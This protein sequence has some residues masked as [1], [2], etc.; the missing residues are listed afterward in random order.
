V[1][2][3]DFLKRAAALGST[4]TL[5]S[6]ALSAP[7][8]QQ[9]DSRR[10]GKGA[11]VEGFSDKARVR[12]GMAMGG[13]GAGYFELRKNGRFYDW[14]IFN[15]FPKETGPPFTLPDGQ[16]EDRMAGLL[17]FEIRYQV[18]GEQPRIKL[19]QLNDSLYEGAEMG[20]AFTF[21]W[22]QAIESIEYS[23]RF[24]LATLVFQDAEMP[25]DLRLEAWS[26]F[27]PHDVKNSS[28]PVVFF[29]FTVV[30]K[31]S[32]KVEITLLMTARNCAGYD[33]PARFYTTEI[34]QS[35]DGLTVS[36]GSGGMDEKA[37]S[38]GQIA[39]ASLSPASSYYAGWGVRHPYYEQVLRHAS[40]PNIDDTNG[41]RSVGEPPPVWL[42]LTNG[43][44][45]LDQSTQKLIVH[46]PDVFSTVAHT[47][48][49][50]GAGSKAA[51]T[52]LYA[53]NFP[54]LY[55]EREFRVQGSRIEGH[56]YSNF[57]SSAKEAIHHGAQQRTELKRRTLEFLDNFF[58]SDADVD[59]LE[60]VNS[61]LNT[62][63]T[64]GRL[65]NS[66]DFGV[67]EGLSATWSWGPI[68]TIDVMFYGSA[69]IIAL[70]PELQKATMRAHARAQSPKGEI[71]H[72]LL[73]DF[74]RGEDST[75][76]IYHRVDLPG[77]FAIMALRDFF[78]T[79]D[80]AYL[81]EMMPAV[82][83]A[84]DYVLRE[85]SGSD[86]AMPIT[87][88][89][90]TSYD[91]FPMFGYASYLLSQW[92]CAMASVRDACLHLGNKN[93]ADR[94]DRLLTKTR[95]SMEERLWN[96]SYY[97]LFSDPG[98]SGSHGNAGDGCLTD[99][100]AGL[101]AAHSSGLGNLLPPEH[102]QGA[103]RTILKRNYDPSLGLKNCS[104]RADGGLS[105]VD[106]DIWVDQ[107]QTPWTGV[108]L[109]F[110]AMLMYEGMYDDGIA[111]AKNVNA[112]YRKN[113]LYWN[114]QEFGGHYFRPMSAWSIVNALLGFSMHCGRLTFDPKVP[115]NNLKLFF[116]TP[117]GT[118]H[119]QRIGGKTSILGLTGK[120]VFTELW[121][122]N[123]KA[124][125][126]AIDGKAMRVARTESD[127]WN[128]F[129]F[130]EEQTLQA[131]QTL[132]FVP[133][134]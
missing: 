108:E 95:E 87:K 64:S 10:D 82:E 72:G 70:F 102:T 67:L 17:F 2:R 18:E 40:L 37:S 61:Q 63:F 106:R 116:V 3:R 77:Q 78:W 83:R 113:G 39:V 79:H 109:A 8:G 86:G 34:D 124:S 68:A 120:I 105:E 94:Y 101:W 98:D 80:D 81:R 26:S 1:K 76:G 129:L 7:A 5:P 75:A 22:I 97:R 99:Q 16:L 85:R 20:I 115:G 126:V 56:F 27:I 130:S 52:F 104:F 59:V 6:L 65:V 112:R 133:A 38:W 53:W 45:A 49:L 9:A 57:F 117:T 41:R 127:R 90:E 128:R 50:A 13:I 118:A 4:V 96:R 66:G 73:K 60:Q 36:M 107:A 25:F 19:L 93:A 11:Y 71:N 125:G 30:A 110:A 35:V 21:P 100:C 24:P 51:H 23:A 92:M 14:N 31:S 88:N 47:C 62:F 74:M 15:N 44:N 58:D 43:R 122:G 132:E 46:D 29:D 91:N 121:M 84:I 32:R 89:I 54:N 119:Y 48:S 33:T 12:S 103:L 114:H 69:P 28:L 131:R 111:V 42:P 123:F 55:N 134:N